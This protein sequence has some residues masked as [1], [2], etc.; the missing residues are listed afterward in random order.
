[1][2]YFA[3]HLGVLVLAVAAITAS[4]DPAT[5]RV[6][7]Q[8]ALA[9]VMAAEVPEPLASAW[10]RYLWAAGRIVGGLLRSEPARCLK[11]INH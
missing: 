5:A 7:L 3:S 4:P 8:I 10:F 9:E 6:P 2:K 11:G 1:M